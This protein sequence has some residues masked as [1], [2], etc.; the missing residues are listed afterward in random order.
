MASLNPWEE[1][2]QAWRR[3]ES[4]LRGSSG[5]GGTRGP[6][7][8]VIEAAVRNRSL[9][10]SVAVELDAFRRL[11]NLDSHEGIAGSGAR[12]CSPNPAAVERLIAIADQLECPLSAVAVMEKASTCSLNTPL[13]DV[14]AKLRDGA[15]VAY[16][17]NGKTWG[18]FDRSQMSRIV[19]RQ[20]KGA[21]TSIDLER[22]IGEH[23]AKI[24]HLE[25]A[26]LEP[27]ANAKRAVSSL[28]AVLSVPDM[29]PAVI[30]VDA[31]TVHH[32]T[33]RALPT[34]ERAIIG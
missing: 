1:F 18:A 33:E 27:T 17:R 8:E 34:A 7:S 14:L 11:R 20:A 2:H 25:V 6:I 4:A 15:E 32:L 9:A 16:Y 12:L 3:V 23:L 29:Y 19:E 13:G 22:S 31:R 30:S 10:A 21:K 5:F 26:V 24:G 28:R